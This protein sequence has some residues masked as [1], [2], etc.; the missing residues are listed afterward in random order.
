MSKRNLLARGF[1]SS[2]ARRANIATAPKSSYGM[3]AK[4]KQRRFGYDAPNSHWSAHRRR[5]ARFLRNIGVFPAI[6]P[7]HED[8]F[9]NSLRLVHPL[10][11][12]RTANLRWMMCR[13]IVW[14][15]C[16]MLCLSAAVTSTLKLVPFVTSTAARKRVLGKVTKRWVFAAIQR[17]RNGRFMTYRA[18]KMVFRRV[19]GSRSDV[20]A[21]DRDSNQATHQH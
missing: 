3:C 9:A 5:Y 10:F 18:I 2:L 6:T 15:S 12:G 4:S 17:P 19:D 16:I 11:L 1:R 8:G 20:S 7:P 13:F 21:A 14:H